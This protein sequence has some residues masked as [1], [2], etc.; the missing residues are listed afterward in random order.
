MRSLGIP[1]SEGQYNG[2]IGLR[3]I[4]YEGMNWINLAQDRVRWLTLLKRAI[5]LRVPSRPGNFLTR[6]V[7][8]SFC[9]RT[10]LHEVRNLS[11]TN[12]TMGY[13][14]MLHQLL[15]FP[16]RDMS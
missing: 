3:K 16:H 10:V 12:Y 6:W 5:F 13:I 9:R 7:G 4:R 8:K 2:K 1:R 14:K 15:L 11:L